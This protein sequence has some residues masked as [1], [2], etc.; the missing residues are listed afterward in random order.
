MARRPLVVFSLLGPSLDAG[1]GAHRWD[2]WRPTVSLCQ[3]EDLVVDRLELVHEP[4]F[5]PLA[6]TVGDDVRHVSPETDVR[7]RPIAWRDAWDFEDVYGA[8]HDVA[9]AYPW[10]PEREDYLVH[11]TTGTHVAQ[12][13]LF[14]LT[15]ARYFPARIIQTSPPRASDRSDRKERRAGSYS[16]IDLDLSR[17]D[18]IASRVRQERRE[19]QS[20]LKSGIET[21]SASFNKMI[22]RVEQVAIASRA[23]I[24]VM[25]PTG[26]G[27]SHLVRRIYELRRQRRLIEGA[28]VE[29]NCATIRG[30]GAMAALFGHVKGAFTGSIGE[31][32]G[33]LRKADRGLLFLDEIGELGADEQAMLLRAIEEKTFYPL[34]SD[35][36]VRSDFQLIAGTNRDLEARAGAGDFRA[37][38]L[39]RINL[40]TFRLP[41]LRE[42]REDIAPNLDYEL[43]QAARDV[44]VNVT[45]SKEARARYLAFAVS[46]EAAW[47]GN[48]RD[49]NAS[50]L[51]MATLAS[52]GRITLDV[53]EEEIERLVT[54]WS[55]MRA[56]DGPR[57]DRVTAALGAA[58]AARLDRFDRVQLEDVL[59]VCAASPSLSECGRVL[60]AESRRAKASANDADR[61]R[62]YLARF[63]L[64]WADVRRG[65]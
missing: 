15:E 56:L 25:G 16:I 43:E 7:V 44:G 55:G 12:I 20:L 54:A 35:K 30:D 28:F 57:A 23:P 53:V 40:W 31:R 26:A 14:L 8:L 52:G 49:L 51:R 50:V 9:R 60:F 47:S 65:A 37:D 41:P 29:V 21:K 58:A 34:G 32:P 6:A 27:K 4:R 19:G 64:T 1:A 17:Y 33:L 63:G 62:K 3:Q 11:I 61:I 42:R 48:F 2:R 45:I 39:A 46:A 59:A 10:K 38:L 22:E 18:R 24:L 5:A 13:C 36:E